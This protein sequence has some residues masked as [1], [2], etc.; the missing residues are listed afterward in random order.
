MNGIVVQQICHFFLPAISDGSVP[1]GKDGTNPTTRRSEREQNAPGYSSRFKPSFFPGPRAPRHGLPDAVP[2]LPVC[3]TFE[4][5]H[6]RPPLLGLDFA[7]D[8]NDATDRKKILAG[9]GRMNLRDGSI[10]RIG[11]GR[12][13]AFAR[14]P[15]SVQKITK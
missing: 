12:A 15:I 8:L 11:I 3:R 1:K 4:P 9:I 13:G 10:D 5:P 2:A 14:I 6:Q 7:V